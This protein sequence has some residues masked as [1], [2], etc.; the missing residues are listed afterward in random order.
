MLRGPLLACLTHPPPARHPPP[1]GRQRPQ[2][3]LNL[4]FFLRLKQS[5]GTAPGLSSPHLPWRRT[6]WAFTLWSLD[7][8]H[9][10]GNRIEVK[11][12][13]TGEMRLKGDHLPSAALNDCHH[14]I[15][16]TAQDTQHAFS[17]NFSRHFVTPKASLYQG[18]LRRS[19][20]LCEGWCT[21]SPCQIAQNRSK[22][23]EESSS[24]TIA[25]GAD[26]GSVQG[27]GRLRLQ[28]K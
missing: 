11:L 1:S 9:R 4:D 3:L 14:F 13:Q 24:E 18:S 20:R 21:T 19:R 22:R 7:Q 8:K 10:K 17:C 26:V 15:V 27:L 6:G 25:V 16:W 28:S 23:L 5:Y 2:N 12:S